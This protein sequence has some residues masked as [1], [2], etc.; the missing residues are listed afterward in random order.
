MKN[1]E[2]Q[3][4]ILATSNIFYEALETFKQDAL[5]QR[6]QKKFTPRAYYIKY[7]NLRLF[8]L[9]ASYLFNV[10]S[11]LTA[12]TLIYFFALSLGPGVL[13]SAL[14]TFCFIALLEIFKR[15][16]SSIFFSSLLQYRKVNL[17]VLVVVGISI[18]S[19]AFSFYGSKKVVQEFTPP[20][21]L[22]VTDTLTNNLTAQLATIDDQIK[23]ANQTKWKGNTTRTAQ[24]AIEQ[25]SKQKAIVQAEIIR[26]NERSD[27]SNDSILIN[28]KSSVQ[29]NSANF[30]LVT[31]L[32][33]ALFLIC[34][35]Y[36]E[37][38]DFRSFAEFAEVQKMEISQ[39][40]LHIDFAHSKA[41]ND[42]QQKAITADHNEITTT[43][44]KDHSDHNGKTVIIDDTSKEAIQQ[45]IKHIKSRIST[46]EHRLRNRIGKPETSL[47]NIEKYKLE[48]DELQKRLSRLS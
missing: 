11:A 8:T 3:K 22:E 33:E 46:A 7:K 36:L 2:N 48:F 35:F 10:F 43:H 15:K 34:A 40:R 20:P 30:G 47:R 19:I 6:L 14:C 4:P 37:Y 17:I 38:Y 45:A 25:L 16:T 42:I 18:L 13:I 1:I 28:H 5:Y 24:K 26:I 12:S 39:K 44:H 32:L 23:E 41:I 21:P 31:L 29:L 9:I 27:K